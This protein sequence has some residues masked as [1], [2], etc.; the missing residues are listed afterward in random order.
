MDLF[1]NEE[2]D[3]VVLLY[4]QFKNAATQIVMNEQFLPVES[5]EESN[6][7]VVDYIFEPNQK[8]IVESLIPKS[9]KTQLFVTST[10]ELR[11]L[12]KF[13]V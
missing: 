7:P 6:A 4:N 1:I 3:K 12:W 9:L 8:E 10:L 13:C 2:Y 11:I 5:S